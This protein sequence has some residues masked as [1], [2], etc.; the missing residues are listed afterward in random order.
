MVRIFDKNNKEE[1][2][3]GQ[4]HIDTNIVKEAV[5]EQRIMQYS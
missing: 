5:E 4:L 3:V 2:N 1:Q